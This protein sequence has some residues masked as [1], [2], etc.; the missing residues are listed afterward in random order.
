MAGMV[1]P[2]LLPIVQGPGTP[3]IRTMGPGR[4]LRHHAT[5]LASELSWLI[6]PERACD[7]VWGEPEPDAALSRAR[8]VEPWES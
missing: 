4:R 6:V 1:I 7:G 2:R 8:A 5:P 3:W